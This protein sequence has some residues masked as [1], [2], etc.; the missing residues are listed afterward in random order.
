MSTRAAHESESDDDADV[1]K[2]RLFR[3]NPIYEA[4]NFSEACLFQQLKIRVSRR[5]GDRV[6]ERQKK[7]GERQKM[8]VGHFCVCVCECVHKCVSV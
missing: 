1:M 6:M 3:F 2:C 7:A 8:S 5:I 4:I